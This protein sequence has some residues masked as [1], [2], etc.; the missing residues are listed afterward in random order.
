[1]FSPGVPNFK[2]LGNS[3]QNCCFNFTM[4]HGLSGP[5]LNFGEIQFWGFPGSGYRLFSHCSKL[6]EEVWDLVYSDGI[7]F[8]NATE[9]SGSMVC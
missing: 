4:H 1:M 3:I 5:I 2:V 6:K 8:S 7:R 9:R